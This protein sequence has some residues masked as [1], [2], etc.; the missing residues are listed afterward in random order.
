MDLRQ[1]IAD[2]HIHTVASDGT[3]SVD[4]RIEQANER[5]LDAIAITDHDLL[6][7]NIKKRT[8][9]VGPIELIAGVEVRAD[10][11]NIKVELLGYFIDP[12]DQDLSEMLAKVRSYRRDRNKQ[13]IDRLRETTTFNQSYDDIRAEAKGILGRP[14]IAK[15]LIEEGVADSISEAFDEYLGTN[16]T[17]FVP[18]ERVRASE[19]IDTLQGAGGVVSLAHPGRIRAD[20][21]EDIVS[22]L[23]KAGLDGI[24]VQYPYDKAPPEGY[25]DVSIAD[26]ATIAEEHGLIRTGGS[27]CHG[28]DSGKFRIGEVRISREQLNTLRQFADRR[29]S[30][31]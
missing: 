25:V 5:N 29:R 23:V 13:M 28:P 1:G 27:D 20:S 6:S 4:E 24:E 14:H 19:V 3:C 8:T 30:L 7:N 11:H 21:I 15:L 16:S 2:L 18:M 10:V 31:S 22:E 17:A 12:Y 9:N 26:V